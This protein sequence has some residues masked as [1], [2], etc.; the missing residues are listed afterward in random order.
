MRTTDSIVSR[1]GWSDCVY[2]YGFTKVGAALQSCHHA[3]DH[4]DVRRDDLLLAETTHIR[5]ERK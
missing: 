1:D 2:R 5:E 3:N 4:P